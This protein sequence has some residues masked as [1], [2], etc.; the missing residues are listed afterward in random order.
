M[1][2][3][4]QS[5]LLLS[6]SHTFLI[7]GSF[8]ALQLLAELIQLLC[9]FPQYQLPQFVSVHPAASAHMCIYI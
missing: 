9:P 2:F 5:P 7:P 8:L 3:G 4:E 1:A 6:S